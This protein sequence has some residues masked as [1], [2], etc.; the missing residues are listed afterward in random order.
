MKKL[1]SER[2]KFHLMVETQDDLWY[3]SQIIDSGDFVSGK[4]LRKMKVG[5]Q[6]DR[7]QKAAKIPVF[8]K[9]QVEKLEWGDT[10]RVLGRVVEGPEDLSHGEHHSFILEPH[11]DFTLEKE[12]WLSYQKEKLEEACAQQH[13]PILILVHDRE[14]AYLAA[15][16]KY[17]YEVIAHLEGKVAKKGMDSGQTSNFY[18]E[19]AAKLF[20]V[21]DRIKPSVLVIAS[22][23]FWKEELM[24][25]VP[26][27][28]KKS[29]VLATCSSVGKEAIDEVLKREEVKTALSADRTAK[30]LKLVEALLKEIAV[31]GKAAYGEKEVAR[32]VQSG[33]AEQLLITDGFIQMK[34][35]DAAFQPIES[36]LKTADSQKAAI[37]VISSKN[38][39]GKR[40]DGL[41]GIAAM[42]RYKIF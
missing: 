42:L 25:V 1:S 27:A 38:D 18:E 31:S 24:K 32:S 11:V 12:H 14:E 20:E 23:A 6:E 22:P 33:A 30:E 2:G 21:A 9:I 8:I 29:I 15:T 37:H 16:K 13:A 39:A 41:G 28:R 36:L 19:I 3:L 10:L 17:G 26:Q 5:T 7:T 35:Q 4:T 34:R 40:L